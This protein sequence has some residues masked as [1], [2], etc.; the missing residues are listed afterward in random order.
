MCTCG[1][2]LVQ[3]CSIAILF[4]G[5]AVL[6]YRSP[7]PSLPLMIMAMPLL[8]SVLMLPQ[9]LVCS[10][11][12]DAPAP[13]PLALRLVNQTAAPDARCLDGSAPAVYWRPGVGNS[14]RSAVLFLEGGGWCLPTFDYGSDNLNCAVRRNSDLGSSENY[15]PS[16]VDTG[17]ARV[18]RLGGSPR[19]P[20]CMCLSTM[21]GEPF[22]LACRALSNA[23]IVRA[24]STP[25]CTSRPPRARY[26][27]GSGFLSVDPAESAFAD[28][29][30]G[31]F[32]YCDGGSFAGTRADPEPAR[33]NS[34]GPIWCARPLARPP[35]CL[36]A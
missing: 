22:V 1:F 19:E 24:R 4:L 2:V 13:R 5:R 36:L 31:Y 16:I 29:A 34:G 14:T 20:V 28:W 32:K 12:A 33:N 10:A 23:P 25:P 26:E 7:P 21:V 9:L 6:Q 11:A 15:P 35:S 8:L 3:Y 18:A 27:G 17:C 30:V